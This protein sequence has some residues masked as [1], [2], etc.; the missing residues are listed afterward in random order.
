MGGGS[1]GC[2]GVLYLDCSE[3]QCVAGR[4]PLGGGNAVECYCLQMDVPTDC[5]FL[6]EF[7]LGLDAILNL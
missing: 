5:H 3:D 6:P 2:L 4:C 1:R 7:R